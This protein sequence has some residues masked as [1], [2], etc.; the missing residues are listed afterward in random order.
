[1]IVSLLLTAHWKGWKSETSGGKRLLL[2]SRLLCVIHPSTRPLRTNK[3]SSR[4]KAPQVDGYAITDKICESILGYTT[5]GFFIDPSINNFWSCR[6]A[7]LK[8]RRSSTWQNSVHLSTWRPF[9]VEHWRIF[10]SLSVYQ[11]VK[12]LWERRGSRRPVN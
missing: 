8:W 6:M 12:L 3:C 2:K 9:V 1:M 4:W 5:Q 10:L 11:T 7:Q